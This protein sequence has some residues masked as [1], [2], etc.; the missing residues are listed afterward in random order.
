MIAHDLYISYHMSF[1]GLRCHPNWIK[2]V[3]VRLVITPGSLHS[4]ICVALVDLDVVPVK[5]VRVRVRV[6]LI[7]LHVKSLLH[8]SPIKLIHNHT[9]DI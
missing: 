4:I 9:L 3:L 5:L 2:L 6:Y 8:L 1:V 7:D